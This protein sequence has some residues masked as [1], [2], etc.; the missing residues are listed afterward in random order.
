MFIILLVQA[1]L[2]VSIDLIVKQSSSGLCTS[3]LMMRLSGCIA[4]TCNMG[5]AYR[6]EVSNMVVIHPIGCCRDRIEAWCNLLHAPMHEA[7]WCLFERMHF[8]L[9]LECVESKIGSFGWDLLLH[10]SPFGLTF[11]LVLSRLI[12]VGLVPVAPVLT[13]LLRFLLSWLARFN[14][15]MAHWPILFGAV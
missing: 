3:L 9:D 12:V 15:A 10:E 14:T 2:P 1:E 11:S 6:S 7:G 8:V 4:P 13:M 5:L